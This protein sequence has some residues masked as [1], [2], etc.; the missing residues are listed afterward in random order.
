MRDIAMLNRCC[1]ATILALSLTTGLTGQGDQTIAVDGR[2][3]RVRTLGVSDVGRR[4][5]VVFESGAGTGMNAWSAVLQDVSAFAT[6]VAYD[7]AGIGGSDDDGRPPTPRHVAQTLH[8]MLASTGIK[9]PY[10][11]VGHSWGGLLIRMFAALYPADVAGLVYVDSTDPRSPEQNTAYLRASGYTD[12]GILEFMERQRQQMSAFVGSRTGP[13]RAEMEVIQA[14]ERSGFAEFRA[15]PPPPS[16]PAAILVSNRLDPQLWQGR[17]CEPAA[18]HEH[19]MRARVQALTSLAPVG[20]E[21]VVT[22]AD[23]SGHEIQRDEPALIVS[24]IRRVVSDQ[25]R[26]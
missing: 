4:P 21:T 14:V 7:R 2:S 16:V 24:A 26:R 9:P 18:C 5:V 1:F 23:R 25:S 22:L 13:Y 8:A 11:L 6:V 15:L 19:W 20:G 17:P 12:D 3:M 10:V